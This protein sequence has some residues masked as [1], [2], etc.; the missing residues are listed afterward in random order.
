MSRL[1]LGNIV[2]DDEAWA[3]LERVHSAHKGSCGR[4]VA[5]WCHMRM[6]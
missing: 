2:R 3:E 4:A 5:S 1:E 6:P